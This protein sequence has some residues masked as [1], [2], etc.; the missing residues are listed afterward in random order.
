MKTYGLIGKTLGHSFSKRYFEEC[1]GLNAIPSADRYLN[2]ELPNIEQLPELI[3]ANP[4]LMG[5]NVTIPYK[6]A[7]IPFLHEISTDA[8]AIGAVNVV[9]IERSPE[10]YG[11]PVMR[12]FNTDYLGFKHAITP[13]LRHHH[14]SALVIGNGGASASVRYALDTMGIAY[15]CV[16]RNPVSPGEFHFEQLDAERV[17]RYQIIINTT[18]I[19]TWPNVNEIPPISM[20]GVTESHL[21]FDLVYNPEETKLMQEAK[22]RGAVTCNGL[23]MLRKQAD[24]AFEIWN[25]AYA[26]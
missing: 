4:D 15:Q 23:I 22:K 19:G 8:S 2:F 16:C 17:G 3:Q 12:G 26:N 13:L 24:L 9:S 11:N 6:S 18:P 14:Q 10:P 21:V 1:Y 5:F 25:K 20:E 7:V